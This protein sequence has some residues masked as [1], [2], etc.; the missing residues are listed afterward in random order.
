MKES[1][2]LN[3][4][5]GPSPFLDLAGFDFIEAFVPDYLHC[6][7]LGVI[8]YFILLW[9]TAKK[10]DLWHIDKIGIERLNKRLESTLPPHE[11]SRCPRTL[12]NIKFWKASEFRAFALYYYTLLDGILPEPFYTH[13]ADLCYAFYVLLQER[14]S[15]ESV[16]K[17]QPLLE[18]FVRDTEYLYGTQHVTYNIHMLIHL[19]RA[20][21]NWG[22]LWTHSTFIP[23][24][25]NGELASLCNG[26]QSVVEQIA[27]SFL[28][29]NQLR[30]EAIQLL[31]EN[32]VPSEVSELLQSLLN[33]PMGS[34]RRFNLCKGLQIGSIKLNGKCSVKSLKEKEKDALNTAMDRFCFNH[35][36][37]NGW[38]SYPR[39]I[40]AE[41]GSIFTTTCYKRS[42]KRVNYCSLM[43]DGRF[44]FIDSILFHPDLPSKSMCMVVGRVLG[45]DSIKILI[46]QKEDQVEFSVIPGQ[47]TRFVGS[48][49]D[50]V[51]YDALEISKKAVVASY[52]S[53]SDSG[54][55]TA[56]PNRL[57]SD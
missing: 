14:A 17:I 43:C 5:F 16:R 56:L 3:G 15:K 40:L 20:V 49:G 54:T 1:D 27:Q 47:A 48:D 8:R 26:T 9:I 4:I 44:I 10:C 18:R 41:L 33:L 53:I 25:F 22:C 19:S 55:V 2:Q 31:N 50:L 29:K 35:V 36:D 52:N 24:W 38:Q 37:H 34:N 11:I 7:C 30:N 39:L 23:E 42:S 46:P 28:M 51:A 21:L 45:K 13:F 6:I 32:D 12:Q 57:E